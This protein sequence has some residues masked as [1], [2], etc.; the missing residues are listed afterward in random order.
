MVSEAKKRAGSD[1]EPP[2]KRSKQETMDPSTNP[3]LAH[4]YEGSAQG[5]NSVGMG[6]RRDA[7]DSILNTFVRHQT[8]AEQA[9]KAEDGPNNAVNGKPL[10]NQYFQILKTRRNLPVHAQR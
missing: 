1:G 3:Y 10:S 8:T 9:Q 2:N 4:M 7:G 6:K 5:S